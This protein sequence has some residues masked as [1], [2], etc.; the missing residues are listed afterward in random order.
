[1]GL[2]A[3]AAVLLAVGLIVYHLLKKSAPERRARKDLRVVA[4]FD[5]R[6][7]WESI[8]KRVTDCY[9]RMH[10][11]WSDVNDVSVPSWMTGWYWQN[12]Q[13]PML[14]ELKKEGIDRV[15]DVKRVG[16]MKPLLFVHKNTPRSHEGSVVVVDVIA[17]VQDY[18]A[19][20]ETGKHKRG[21]RE[22]RDVESIWSFVLD[23]EGWKLSDVESAS[24]AESYIASIKDLPTIEDTLEN[25]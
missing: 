20:S 23:S 10:A 24:M 22:Y 17:K 14:G 12:R 3:V 1:M 19:D 9:Y 13:Q 18:F 15:C 21:S 2:L 6:F 25:G 5:P 7:E 8:Q 11:S 4:E 16:K